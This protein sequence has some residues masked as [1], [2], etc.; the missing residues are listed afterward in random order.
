MHIRSVLPVFLFIVPVVSTASAGMIYGAVYECA[1]D[2]VNRAM[3]EACSSRFPELAKQAD[4]ALAA[5]R[6]RNLAKAS[7]AAKACST[8]ISAATENA[9]TSDREA[10]RRLIAKTKAEMFSS[11]EAKIRK[12]G[13]GACHE[14][15]KQLHTIGGPLE[16]R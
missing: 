12:Q 2:E 7:A 15:I 4:E 5:W 3:V 9:P 14:G 11:F 13:A 6:D 16:I 1:A 8:D 10:V